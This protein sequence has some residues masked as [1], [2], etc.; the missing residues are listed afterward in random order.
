MLVGYAGVNE[1]LYSPMTTP[2]FQMMKARNESMIA[3]YGH[4]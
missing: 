3:M 2:P 4:I 1:R